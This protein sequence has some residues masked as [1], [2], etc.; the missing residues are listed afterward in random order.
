MTV[1]AVPTAPGAATAVETPAGACC[2]PRG[3]GSAPKEEV[4]PAGGTSVITG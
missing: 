3:S 2:T 4:V 1:L